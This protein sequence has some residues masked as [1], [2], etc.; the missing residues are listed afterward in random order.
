MV[1][2][3]KYITLVKFEGNLYKSSSSNL[4]ITP[5]QLTEFQASSSNIV[6]GILLKRV[7]SHFPKMEDNSDNNTIRIPI[8][9]PRCEKTGL[10]GFRP[11]PT[12]TGLYSHSRWLEI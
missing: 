1:K 2:T 8:F 4:L 12:Q 3:A 6:R 7:F 10:R 9:E 11:G 5:Y